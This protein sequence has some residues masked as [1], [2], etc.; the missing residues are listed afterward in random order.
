MFYTSY[1]S[2]LPIIIIII[3]WYVKSAENHDWSNGNLNHSLDTYII[4][5]FE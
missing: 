2:L 3:F 5:N 1:A 4:I